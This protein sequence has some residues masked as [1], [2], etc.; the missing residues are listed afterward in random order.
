MCRCR[1]TS[2]TLQNGE[3][4]RF[5]CSLSTLEDWVARVDR[6]LSRRVGS[7]RSFGD[8][9]LS[10]F[11]HLSTYLSADSP[12]SLEIRRALKRVQARSDVMV[13]VDGE[14]FPASE[15]AEARLSVDSSDTLEG[16][17]SGRQ[18]EIARELFGVA[19]FFGVT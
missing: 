9:G 15:D 1:L 19:R 16:R 6:N 7:L 5:E 2:I 11:Q 10:T 8:V 4:N 14:G 17:R 3:T 13:V 18:R 12:D